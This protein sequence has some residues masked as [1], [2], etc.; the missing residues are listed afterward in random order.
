MTERYISW[1]R[2]QFW[3]KDRTESTLQRPFWTVPK[4]FINQH[5]RVQLPQFPLP[6]MSL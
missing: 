5:L 1:K 4:P 3:Q 6:T 2:K